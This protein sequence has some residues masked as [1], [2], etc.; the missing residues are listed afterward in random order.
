MQ[1]REEKVFAE[2]TI[3]FFFSDH[4]KNGFRAKQWLYDGGIHVPLIVRWPARPNIVNPGKVVDEVVSLVDLAA[5]SLNLAGI[6]PPEHLE[7]KI[8]LGPDAQ[9]NNYVVAARDRGDET[10][11]RMRAVRTKNFKYIRNYYP[12]IPYSQTNQYKDTNVLSGSR[13]GPT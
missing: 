12:E 10:F 6:E 4:G 7:G 1:A 9:V 5:T 2:N 11:H 13:L 8:I 3:V